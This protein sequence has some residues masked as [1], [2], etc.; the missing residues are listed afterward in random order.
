MNDDDARAAAEE[1]LLTAELHQVLARPSGQEQ[2]VPLRLRWPAA[3]I[4]LLGALTVLGVAVLRGPAASPAQQPEFDVLHPAFERETP[5]P[6]E[7]V[8]VGNLDELAALPADAGAVALQPANAE[9]LAATASRRPLRWL[10]VFAPPDAPPTTLQPLATA[11]ELESLSLGVPL[12]ARELRELRK[13]PRLQR[14]TLHLPAPRLDGETG[15]DLTEAVGLRCVALIGHAPTPEGIAALATLPLLDTLLVLPGLQ[16]QVPQPWLAEL[17]RLRGLRALVL[18]NVPLPGDFGDILTRLPEL[19]LLSLTLVPC[20]DV[21]LAA[22]PAGLQRLTLSDFG[23]V[24][25]AGILGLRRCSNLRALGLRGGW[26]GRLHDALCQLVRQL[27]LERFDSVVQSPTDSLWSALQSRPHL[28][29]LRVTQN[30]AS[31]DATIAGA[32][33]CAQLREL[34]LVVPQLPD[35]QS[36]QPLRTLRNLRRLELDLPVRHRATL[37]AEQVEALRRAVDAEF[38]IVV[39]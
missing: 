26:P 3:V 9:L 13:L 38:E 36:L 1:R 31:A 19:R 20:N 33:G 11:D 23:T 30:M 16:E 28:R 4:A 2:Q 22:V 7:R 24:S 6:R 10:G 39:R 27:P 15:R 25:P 12:A 17:P 35:A 37:Q 32:S 18:E 21:L 8:F 29:H 5:I 34:E 14:L